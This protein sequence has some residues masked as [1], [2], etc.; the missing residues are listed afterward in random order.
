M[1]L[2]PP[3]LPD[4]SDRRGGLKFTRITGDPD[5]PETLISDRLA[6]YAASLIFRSPAAYAS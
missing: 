3:R 1:G 2:R 4:F 6:A 5:I